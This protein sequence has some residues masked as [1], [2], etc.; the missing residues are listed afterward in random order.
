MY[1]GGA[2]YFLLFTLIIHYWH[3][4]PLGGVHGVPHVM[5][6]LLEFLALCFEHR[7]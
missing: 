3:S 2:Y 6:G 5:L 7:G 1:S 4:G